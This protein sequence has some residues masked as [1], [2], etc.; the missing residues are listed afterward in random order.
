MLIKGE[1]M[2]KSLKN[3]IKIRDMLKIYDAEALRLLVCS[4]HYR[5]DVSYTEDLMKKAE[6]KLRYMYASFSIFYNAKPSKSDKGRADIDD[7]VNTLETGMQDAMDDDFNTPV[8]FSLLVSAIEKLR[9]YAESHSEV[10]MSAKEA[11]IS[12]VLAAGAIF[13]VLKKDSYKDKLPEAAANLIKERERLRKEKKYAD[14]DSIRNT[15]K[16][17]HGIIVEDSEYGPIWYGEK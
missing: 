17:A 9:S 6:S 14:A 13:G 2:S 12:K 16:S 3:F 5:K 7:I 10:N 15:L 11:A 8:A 1:K 4:T